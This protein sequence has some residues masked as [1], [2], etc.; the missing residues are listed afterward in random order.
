MERLSTTG[1]ACITKAGQ[2]AVIKASA[3]S[4]LR[5]NHSSEPR[6]AAYLYIVMLGRTSAS[7]AFRAFGGAH[8][9]AATALRVRAL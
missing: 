5:G 1:M 8:R 6:R 3:R 9:A 2:R 7:A 4:W